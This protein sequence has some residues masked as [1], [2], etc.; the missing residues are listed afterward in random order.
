MSPLVTLIIGTY[1]PM[2]GHTSRPMDENTKPEMI[3]D[4][5]WCYNFRLRTNTH[6]QM[7]WK[8]HVERATLLLT[9]ERSEGQMRLSVL[10]IIIAVFVATLGNAHAHDGERVVIGTGGKTGVYY[11]TGKVLCQLLEDAGIPCKAEISAGSIDNLFDLQKGQITFAMAQSDWQFHAYR[12]SSKWDGD[13]FETLRSVFSIYPEPV[14]IVVKRDAEISKWRDLRGKRVNVGNHGS[15]SRQTFEEMLSSNKWKNMFAE[16]HELP[17]SKQ[18]DAFCDNQF[19]A[20]VFSI[21][22]PNQAM[23]RAV[24]ECNGKIIGPDRIATRKLATAA[25]PYYS[26]TTIAGGTYWSGQ[27]AVNTFGVLATLVARADTDAEV[28][29]TLVRQVFEQFE[30]FKSLHP[31]FALSLPEEMVREGLS[32]P[33][34]PAAQTYFHSKGWID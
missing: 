11:A 2:Q 10:G 26:K 13:K 9:G 34:H 1:R 17:S 20:F 21:G 28:V 16:V 3:V 12:G 15:G 7:H 30:A 29:D 5:Q 25:R 14:Q 31:A 18:I 23:N 24:N 19:D 4:D 22:I 6:A 33:L 32:A 8:T 27:P